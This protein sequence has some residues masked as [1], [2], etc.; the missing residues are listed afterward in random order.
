M[1]VASVFA[2]TLVPVFSV[3]A[4]VKQKQKPNNN[5]NAVVLIF[6]FL[7]KAFQ[8]LPN[9]LGIN[10]RPCNVACRKNPAYFFSLTTHSSFPCHLYLSHTGLHSFLHSNASSH[11]RALDSII[12]SSWNPL[13]LSIYPSSSSCSLLP[14]L[15]PQKNSPWIDC[16]DNE[17]PPDVSSFSPIHLSLEVFLSTIY[18]SYNFTFV[19]ESLI[20]LSL[21]I[22][23]KLHEDRDILSFG[24]TFYF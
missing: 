15:L 9:A 14:R 7:F 21:P 24:L 18:H 16:S 10:A 22:H 1:A 4:S 19:R 20:Y 2:F 12:L 11:H 8:S 13:P 23:G 6:S 17:F 3:T 5:S